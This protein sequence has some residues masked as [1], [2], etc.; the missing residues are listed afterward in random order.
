MDRNTA[1]AFAREYRDKTVEV[2]LSSGTR[3][4]IRVIDCT[5]V[6]MK[7]QVMDAPYGLDQPAKVQI[8]FTQI[9]AAIIPV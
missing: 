9:I 8:D 1:K 3:M 7:G 6:W 4:T 2:H 5:E